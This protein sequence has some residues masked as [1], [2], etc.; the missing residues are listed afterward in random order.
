M[1]NI[2]PYF[3]LAIFDPYSASS[4]YSADRHS[5]IQLRWRISLISISSSPKPA[6][7]ILASWSIIRDTNYY[8][9]NWLISPSR[10]I[11][12]IS[13][14]VDRMILLPSFIG[15][16]WSI[17]D[18][19]FLYISCTYSLEALISSLS[20]SMIFFLYCSWRWTE[21]LSIRQRSSR[22]LL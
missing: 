21:R 17:N 1:V 20:S 2:L 11:C 18:G 12:R 13:F 7:L 3:S 22:V 6:L 8:L 14:F 5:N 9:T 19:M 10:S 16:I 15:L 4:I